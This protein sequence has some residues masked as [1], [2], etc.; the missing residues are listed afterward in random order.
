MNM[1]I[2]TFTNMEMNWENTPS[3]Q[4]YELVYYLLFWL[5]NSLFINYKAMNLLVYV[6]IPGWPDLGGSRI[7]VL[8][9]QVSRR[10]KSGRWRIIWK[11][12]RAKP[13]VEQLPEHVTDKSNTTWTWGTEELLLSPALIADWF[14]SKLNLSPKVKRE[15][16][17]EEEAGEMG[18]SSLI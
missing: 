17:A 18:R 14:F 10:S 8:R 5:N 7:Q 13:E 16:Y 4:H 2:Y 15:N 12:R 6:K 1:W 11:P 3:D 9:S